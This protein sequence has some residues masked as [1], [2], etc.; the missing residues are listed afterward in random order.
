MNEH[1]DEILELG[2][3]FDFD[4]FQ[5]VRREFFAHTTEPA[6]SFNNCKFYVNSACLSKFPDTDYVQVLIN[7][8][9]RIMALRPCQEGDRDSFAWV[10]PVQREAETKTAYLQILLCPNGFYDGLGSGIPLQDFRTPRP[11]EWRMPVDFRPDGHR[12]VP[13][14]IRPRGKSQNFKDPGFPGKLEGSIWPTLP[15]AP[16]VYADQHF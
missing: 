5:V 8:Q 11:C 1:E 13:K 12:D 15:G 10:R 14:G 6:V 3:D 9:S 16:P 2:D 4:G 7:R